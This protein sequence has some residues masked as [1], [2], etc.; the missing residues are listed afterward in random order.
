MLQRDKQ[1]CK[2]NNFFFFFF[3]PSVVLVNFGDSGEKRVMVLMRDE[4][5]DIE[6][7]DQVVEVKDL[8][9]LFLDYQKKVNTLESNE[10][11]TIERRGRLIEWLKKN[12][13]PVKLVID[14]VNDR[15]HMINILDTVFIKP[16]YFVENCEST[17]EIIL[18]KVR[19]LVENLN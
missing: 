7:V 1:N 14:N 3:F 13:L 4:I 12:R 10:E 9:E 5:V 17:N 2:L 18:D 6:M 19:K 16:P 8:N 15:N 11:D